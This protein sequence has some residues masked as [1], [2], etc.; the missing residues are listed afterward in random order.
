M[1]SILTILCLALT[2]CAVNI[3]RPELP[4]LADATVKDLCANYAADR[5][6]QVRAELERRAE[7]S[8][9]EWRRIKRGQTNPSGMR[10]A[11][12]WCAWGLPGDFGDIT[13]TPT[14]ATRYRY[15]QEFAGG[16][17]IVVKDG[18]VVDWTMF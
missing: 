5:S 10:E 13:Q 6:I 14:G 3:Q 11:V 2:G 7:F 4:A 15:A 8:A 9:D 18:V 12:L 16:V 1:R 17:D